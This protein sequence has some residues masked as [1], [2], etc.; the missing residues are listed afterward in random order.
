MITAEETT[1]YEEKARATVAVAFFRKPVDL[2]EMV[3]VIHRE[4][5]GES[6]PVE[7]SA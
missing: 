1:E 4:L 7:S 2:D 3:A 6:P 5:L